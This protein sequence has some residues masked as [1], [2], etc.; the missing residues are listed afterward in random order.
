MVAGESD[1][2]AF[3]GRRWLST[4]RTCQ[5]GWAWAASKRHTADAG[6]GELPGNEAEPASSREDGGTDAAP[7][8][9]A[10][11]PG[12]ANA[13][14]VVA[15]VLAA[16]AC[17]AD[18][19]AAEAVA[20]EEIGVEVVGE[21]AGRGIASK[22]DASLSGCAVGVDG[23]PDNST[24][25]GDGHASPGIQLCTTTAVVAGADGLAGPVV[26]ASLGGRSL[27]STGEAGRATGWTAA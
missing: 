10:A 25:T 14:A 1:G 9:G 27:E 23:T 22:A 16:G 20:A 19:S 8:S 17:T 7:S 6:A 21:V 11:T 12:D 3:P 24:A 15:K 2:D 26:P 18:E 4:G 13:G 5:C